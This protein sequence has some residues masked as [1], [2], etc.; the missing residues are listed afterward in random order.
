M[1]TSIVDLHRPAKQP[2]HGD[3]FL[4][5]HIFQPCSIF[6]A[7]AE[8]GFD[9]HVSAFFVFARPI[10]HLSEEGGKAGKHKDTDRRCS[11]QCDVIGSDV[12]GRGCSCNVYV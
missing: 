9:N 7:H 5:G 3:V 2:S 1:D 4:A 11:T 6:L 8:I 10:S 12:N